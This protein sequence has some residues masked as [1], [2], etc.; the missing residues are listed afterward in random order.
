MKLKFKR[1]LFKSRYVKKIWYYVKVRLTVSPV[2]TPSALREFIWGQG[3]I[4]KSEL[5]RIIWSY[6][7]G[8]KSVSADL[9]FESIKKYSKD[10]QLN[11]IN[12]KNLKNYLPDFP[13]LSSCVPFQKKSNL[14]RL[15]LLEKYGGIWVDYSTIVCSDWGWVKDKIDKSGCEMLCFYNEKSGEYYSDSS[16][17]I[18][19]N[20]FLAAVKNSDFLKE[21]RRC[22]QDCL[23]SLDYRTYF[24][25]F[26]NYEDLTRNF[27]C[28]ESEYLSYFVCYIAAQYVMN[29]SNNYRI[30]MINAEDDYYCHYYRVNPASAARPFADQ[31]LLA[32]N[33][34]KCNLIKVNGRNRRMLDQYLEYSCYT[35]SSVMGQYVSE[36]SW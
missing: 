10:Y 29:S 13:E 27:V 4:C 8:E 1:F 15:M 11:L 21:W 18:V 28:K 6:W 31:V 20:G 25:R 30:W 23:Q 24:Q 33:V 19:E 34:R 2:V 26:E 17:P 36:R 14:V 12:D 9:A 16:A 7:E 3:E 5:P 35:A 32:N 22:Y